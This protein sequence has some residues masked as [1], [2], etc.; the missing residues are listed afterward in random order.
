MTAMHL[1]K[2]ALFASAFGPALATIFTIT[3]I[4]GVALA[5]TAKVKGLRIART[6]NDASRGYVGERAKVIME[7]QDNSG[8][9]L[10]REL[11]IEKKE[12]GKGGEDLSK[13]TVLSPADVKK[14]RLLTWGKKQEDDQWLYLPSMKRVKRITS[15]LRSGSFMGSEFSYEDFGTKPVERYEHEFLRDDKFDGRPV[16]VVEQTPKNGESAYGKEI[17]WYDQEYKA[18][19]KLELFA[20]N[21]EPL[22]IAEFSDYKKLDGKFWRP[23]RVKM[24]NLQTKRS[25]ILAWQKRDLGIKFQ[26]RSFASESLKD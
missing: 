4:P 19:V 21:G 22:K 17:V 18:P 15:Q 2:Q 6:C 13:L 20:K 10:E 25:S 16:W 24:K 12:T 9:K 26:E 3:A 8:E 7:L 11:M 1:L 23:G 14:T 5:E